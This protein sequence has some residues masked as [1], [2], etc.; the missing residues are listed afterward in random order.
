MLDP[1]FASRSLLVQSSTEMN[2]VPI[3]VDPTSVEFLRPWVLEVKRIGPQKDG[4]YVVPLKS[5]LQA[6]TLVSIGIST[7]WA[8]ESAFSQLC[9]RASIYMFDRSSGLTGFLTSAIHQLVDRQVPIRKRLINAWG[10]VKHAVS[11][12]VHQWRYGFR[13]KRKWVLSVVSDHR[14]EVSI[15]EVLTAIPQS[16]HVVLKIDVEGAEYEFL[17][18]LKLWLKNEGWC[19]TLLIEL[20]DFV[21][22]RQEI[23]EFLDDVQEH[24]AVAHL[25]VN[26]YGAISSGIPSVVEITMCPRPW[27]KNERRISLPLDGLDYPN[28]PSLPD[29]LILFR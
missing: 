24:L 6:D 15:S 3:V 1:E 2:T 26:N 10:Y 19:T 16:A 4:G 9:P 23:E 21:D 13:F 14:R 22:H 18:E 17:K 25:H 20:H 11:F 8:F 29:P 12:V 27:V 5:V 7:D 28:N